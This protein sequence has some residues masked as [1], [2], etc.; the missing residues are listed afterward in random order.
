M[1]SLADGDKEKMIQGQGLRLSDNNKMDEQGTTRQTEEYE[2]GTYRI[3][4]STT[5]SHEATAVTCR[6]RLGWNMALPC[7]RTI[8]ESQT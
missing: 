5:Q 1:T 4:S 6:E 3:P 7:F 8:R 2:S